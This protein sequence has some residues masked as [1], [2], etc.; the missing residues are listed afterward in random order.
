[1]EAGSMQNGCRTA[2]EGGGHT[3]ARAPAC[4]HAAFCCFRIR[5]YLLIVKPDK[6]APQITGS[7]KSSAISLIRNKRLINESV[8][9]QNSTFFST[10]SS[11]K[12]SLKKKKTNF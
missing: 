6:K 11:V 1:M 4:P 3:H 2:Q 10:H 5:S 12:D 8:K 9:K 7:A